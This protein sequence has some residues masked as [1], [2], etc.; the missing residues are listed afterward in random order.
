MKRTK[1]IVMIT[2][3]LIAFSLAACSKSGGKPEQAS[4]SEAKTETQIGQ[5]RKS[6]GITAS[7][8]IGSWT[9]RGNL[10][11]FEFKTGGTGVMNYPGDN[12]KNSQTFTWE[13]DG[14]KVS[15]DTEDG[16]FNQFEYIGDNQ[17]EDIASQKWF[18]Q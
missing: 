11:V 7:T 2:L 8:I 14:N 5:A 10:I 6:N 4:S 9:D 15:I 3:L 18:K 1:A 16:G 12:S 13:I 17:L